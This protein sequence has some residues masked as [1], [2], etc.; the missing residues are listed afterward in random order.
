MLPFGGCNKRGRLLFKKAPLR[1]NKKVSIKGGF[2]E[3]F[4]SREGRLLL[5]RLLLEG[6]SL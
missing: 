1:G 2:L 5:R 4:H 6:A 3:G